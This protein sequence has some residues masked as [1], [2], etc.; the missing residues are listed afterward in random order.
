MA[1]EVRIITQPENET[2]DVAHRGTVRVHGDA[3]ADALQHH[4]AGE[5]VHATPPDRPLVHMVLWDEDC[6]CEV[7]G[8]MTV[9]GD[10]AAPVHLAH[11]F[12]NDHSQTHRFETALASPVHHALQ[13]RTPLQV[14]F[15][16]TWQVASDYT[17]EIRLGE[18]RVIGVR[19]TGATIAKPLPCED[20]TP[21]GDAIVTHPMH[22]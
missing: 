18:S 2:F 6:A 12:E 21:C 9:V 17:V 1:D 11:R 13:M 14:R 20:E 16:N 19:I 3:K 8:R 22:P 5:V 10:K 4:V 7:N 15:C